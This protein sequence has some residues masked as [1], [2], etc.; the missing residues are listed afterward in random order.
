MR[1][2]AWLILIAAG[3][4]IGAFAFLLYSRSATAAEA[5]SAISRHVSAPVARRVLLDENTLWHQLG[6]DG[7]TP[8]HPFSSPSFLDANTVLANS[9]FADGA[10]D[11]VYQ[12]DL[13][14]QKVRHLP[15]LT[16]EMN[17]QGYMK[18]DNWKLSPDHEWLL[19]RDGWLEKE[20]AIVATRRDGSGSRRWEAKATQNRHQDTLFWLPGSGHYFVDFVSEDGGRL[21]RAD[22]YLLDTPRQCRSRISLESLH[23]GTHVLGLLPGGTAL[24]AD[25]WDT[26][27]WESEDHHSGV[28]LI[29]FRFD[30]PTVWARRN[31]VRFGKGEG[32]RQIILSPDGR[33]LAWPISDTAARCV[34]LQISRPDGTSRRTALRFSL[35]KG[36][37]SE[38]IHC[39][40]WTP[41]CRSVLI[42]HGFVSPDSK[43]T[44]CFVE[45]IEIGSLTI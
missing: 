42:E 22:I 20:Y 25:D 7:D 29:S 4:G 26:N 11:S 27:H 40:G 37:D 8:V 18:P 30:T 24:A 23:A 35:P 10:F 2:K 32:I 36:E 34:S 16:D 1:Q 13:R 14:T 45:S 21:N 41:D 39:L 12:L 28:H 43:A 44:P 31:T 15:R 19:W 5:S 33:H 3:F 9:L 38:E 17:H 6:R